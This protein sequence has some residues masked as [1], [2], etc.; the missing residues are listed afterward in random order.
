[1]TVKNRK[2]LKFI[3]KPFQQIGDAWAVDQYACD[4]TAGY[5]RKQGL[6]EARKGIA[7]MSLILLSLFAMEAIFFDA[8][9]YEQSYWYT[10]TL[11]ALLSLHILISARAAQ[12]TRSLYLLGTTLLIISGT[13]IVL[14]AHKT[15]MF[16]L[17]LFSSVILLYL[18]V[19]MVPWGLRE[20]LVVLAMI[21]VT[22]T[23]SIFALHPFGSGQ[24]LRSHFDPQ[25]VWSLQLIMAGAIVISLAMV[26]RNILVRK[27]DIRNRFALEQ[28]NK[29]L[30]HLSNRDALTGAWNRRFLKNAFDKKASEWRRQGQVY[31]FAFLDIDNFKPINDQWGH[32]FGDDVLRCVTHAFT[33]VLGD[34]GFFIRMGGDEFA[35]LFTSDDP[36]RLLSSGVHALHRR[37]SLPTGNT[38]LNIAVSLGMVSV[39]PDMPVVEDAVYRAADKALYEAKE[40]K[41]GNARNLNLVRHTLRAGVDADSSNPERV[42]VTSIY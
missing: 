2:M 18:V 9:N 29:R 22:F 4:E 16:D 12:D 25:T 7:D 31:H 20:A 34:D 17:V 28:K 40:R 5:A 26:V 6:P 35:L 33:E 14:L 42:P 15:G 32:D 13:A 3:K 8:F 38:E 30:M 11:L 23:T 1:M 36:E 41:A 27:S 24:I 19:P 21:Y 37:I 39:L 10:S